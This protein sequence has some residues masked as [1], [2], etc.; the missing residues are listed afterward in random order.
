MAKTIQLQIV[1]P[2][3]IVFNGEVEHFTAP[4]A[5]GPFQVLHNHAP[6]VS[7]LVAG[8]FRVVDS[9]GKEEVFQVTGGF[10]ELHNNSAT[11]LADAVI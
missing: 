10:L 2:Q 8:P 1:T 7:T 6:I 5:L 3:K 11:V 4:G 9:K